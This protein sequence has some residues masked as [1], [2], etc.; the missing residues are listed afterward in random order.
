MANTP[1][2]IVTGASRGL[3][4][5]I[6][7]WLVLAGIRVTLVARS[8]K[9]LVALGAALDRQGTAATHV[10][11]ADVSENDACERI[12]EA[13]LRHFGRI[14]ALVNNAGILEPVGR[15]ADTDPEAWLY[16]LRV[17]LAAPF[18]LCRAALPALRKARGRVINIS[19]GAAVKAI[20]AW[21]AYCV[22]KAGLTHFTKLLAEEEPDVTSIAL[23]PG[24]VDTAMQGLIRKAGPGRMAPDKAAYFQALK[25]DNL[26][27]SPHVPAR[28][29]AWLSLHAPASW[30]GAFMDYDDPRIERPA[31]SEFG[32]ELVLK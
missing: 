6:A 11:A 17:N 15:I 16:N 30:S 32:E 14:D 24:V 22:A 23:R 19:S 12:V 27:V 5:D 13:S 2:V 28:A 26:L 25:D 9:D 20:E 7:K 10:I 3:G 29:A 1:A 8:E 18:Q 21:S 4:A 31:L